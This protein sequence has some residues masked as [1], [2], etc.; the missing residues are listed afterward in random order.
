MEPWS[1]SSAEW[2]DEVPMRYDQPYE[3]GCPVVFRRDNRPCDDT[4]MTPTPCREAVQ[5][6]HDPCTHEQN[7]DR[8]MRERDGRAYRR[9]RMPGMVYHAAHDLEHLYEPDA[10][11]NRGTL[12][13]VLDK[14]ME[15]F[16]AAFC[17]CTDARQAIAFAIW[18]LRLYLNT[19]PAD[20]HALSMY[21]ALCNQAAHP[22]YACT[23]APCDGAKGRWTWLDDPWPWEYAAN[24]DRRV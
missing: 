22:N 1:N 17:A 15:G 23:F 5:P 24:C 8:D 21:E 2:K 14:P 4:R 6:Q 3:R 10:A 13:G 16:D 19:H 12:F 11:L 18:E 20:Q 9:G 7:P